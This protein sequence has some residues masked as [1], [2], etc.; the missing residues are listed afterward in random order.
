M[1]GSNQTDAIEWLNTDCFCV[2]VDGAALQSALDADAATR[3]L[4][5]SLR[6]TH[7]YLFAHAPIFVSRDNVTAME[8]LVAAVEAVVAQPGYREA[9]LGWA[10]AIA[11]YEPGPV[12]ALMGFDFHVTPQGPRLIEINTNAGGAFLN[13]ALARAQIACCAPVL[14]YLEEPAGAD[15]PQAAL[16]EMFLAEWRR[17]RGT[18]P[19]NR[20]AIVDGAPAK[21]YLYPEFLLASQMFREHGVEAVICDPCE[22]Q[23]DPAGLRHDGRL[24]DLI[25]NR[26]TDF[27]LE[28]SDHAALR[29]A[30][31]A[32]SVVVTP[33]PRAHALYADKRNLALLGDAALL[34][35]WG[36]DAA[37]I[38]TL[39]RAIPRTEILD[40]ARGDEFWAARRNLFFKP[41]SG[42]GGRATYRGDKLTRKVWS[43]ILQG[44]YVAQELVPP[45]ERS[46]RVDGQPVRLKL[47]LRCYVYDGR[48]LSVAA[49]L[50]R[51]QTTNFRTPG[52]GFA[53]VF[54][55]AH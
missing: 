54:C 37:T 12:G 46:V 21:Q 6:H 53:T 33:N 13:A 3:G 52:G 2:T 4:Y 16:F 29:D 27:A 22:L 11:R 25:Y 20:V 43:E 36:I 44:R 51:G 14:S 38:E 26:L 49:R 19:L 45:S 18:A 23:R 30:Y 35:Q 7:A 28:Q 48:V 31:V 41:V 55:P 34:R 9:A 24:V 15:R 32:G 5:E 39:Q 42:F 40:P 50:Y 1:T 10:P 47:D 8:R 17:Q